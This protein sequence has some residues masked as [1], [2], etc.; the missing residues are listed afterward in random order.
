[1]KLVQLLLPVKSGE[2]S[3]RDGFER[4]LA[5]LTERFGGATASLQAPAD[6]LWRDSGETER[7]RM[8]VVEAMVE[9]FEPVWWSQYRTT[10]EERFEEEEIVIRAIVMEK[11]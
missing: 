3:S 11:V 7:D 9:D 10:L 1:M 5:E 8:V 6:G 4:V 2:Q